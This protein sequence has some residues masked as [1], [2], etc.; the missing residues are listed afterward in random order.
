MAEW[1]IAVIGGEDLGVEVI[2]R[3]TNAAVYDWN[4]EES[5]FALDN[6]TLPQPTDVTAPAI[7]VTDELRIYAENTYNS[8]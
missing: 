8:F 7:V 5:A 2:L 6:T 4:A 3:E 1:Q